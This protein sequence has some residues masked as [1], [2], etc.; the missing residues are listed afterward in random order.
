M[1]AETL[2]NKIPK[3]LTQLS[4]FQFFPFFIIMIHENKCNKI[5][6]QQLC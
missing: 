2:I 5:K 1:N 3:A 6:S 4:G